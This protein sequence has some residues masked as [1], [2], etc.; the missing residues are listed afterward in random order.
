LRFDHF[1]ERVVRDSELPL[2][3]T[4][5]LLLSLARVLLE[6]QVGDP[7]AVSRIQDSTDL[8]LRE[9]AISMPRMPSAPAGP[10]ALTPFLLGHGTLPRWRR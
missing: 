3:S 6:R 8:L 10:R 1:E 2:V 5:P 9:D 4:T 7:A